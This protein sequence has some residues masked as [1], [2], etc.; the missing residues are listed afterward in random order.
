MSGV[1]ESD[2]DRCGKR[3]PVKG[4]GSFA[5]CDVCHPS[6]KDIAA[7]Y[8][9]GM[10]EGLAI[11]RRHARWFRDDDGGLHSFDWTDAD[12]ELERRLRGDE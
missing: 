4:W 7:A 1:W 12:A 6:A 8:E 5:Y 11:G 3:G 10:R 9:R 2:C